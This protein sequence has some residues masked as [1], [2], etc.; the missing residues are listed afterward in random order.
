MNSNHQ[1]FILEMIKHGDKLRAYKTAY[2]RAKDHSAIKAA[3]RL[4]RRPEIAGEIEHAIAAIRHDAYKEA[5][6]LCLDQQKTLLLSIMKKREILTQIATCQM[7][8]GRYVK[9]EDGY[10]MVYE[11]PRPRDI[12]KAIEVDTQLEQACNRARNGKDPQLAN[13]DVYID[14]RLA[15]DPDAAIDPE[16]PQGLVMLPK[17]RRI[18]PVQ[19]SSTPKAE[20]PEEKISNNCSGNKREQPLIQ[21][22]R[23]LLNEKNRAI[24]NDPVSQSFSKQLRPAENTEQ[25]THVRRKTG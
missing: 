15:Q 9:E 6:Q 25:I 22:R 24:L 17:K 23:Q 10:R 4:L 13:F 2:P 1:T 16:V 12:I 21:E 14:G 7:K 20:E 5:Y 3:E 8:V 18:T 11:D 19:V